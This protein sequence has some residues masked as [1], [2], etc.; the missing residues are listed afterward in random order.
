MYPAVGTGLLVF[1]TLLNAVVVED[2]ST[3]QSCPACLVMSV[4]RRLQTN[5]AAQAT[6]SAFSL[7]CSHGAGLTKRHADPRVI[8]MPSGCVRLRNVNN[9][10]ITTHDACAAV[11]V[12]SRK[13]A[14]KQQPFAS[15]CMF[16]STPRSQAVEE[17]YRSNS[18]ALDNLQR[19][20][21]CGCKQKCS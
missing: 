4:P 6:H 15:Q 5:G 21:C 19:R 12:V 14:F 10:Y 13:Q 20:L 16:A 2:M 1:Q 18:C 8:S 7:R 9:H 3:T 17:R 11:S